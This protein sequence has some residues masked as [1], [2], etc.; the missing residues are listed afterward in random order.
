MVPY[1]IATWTANH[2]ACDRVCIRYL[3][4]LDIVLICRHVLYNVLECISNIIFG[5]CSYKYIIYNAGTVFICQNLADVCRRQILTYKD[6]P[7]TEKMKI[8]IVA[9]DP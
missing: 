2:N 3:K 4:K 5:S 1:F 7:R 9:V 8:F 6:C